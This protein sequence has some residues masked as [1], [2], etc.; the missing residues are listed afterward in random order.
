MDSNLVHV[1]VSQPPGMIRSYTKLQTVFLAPT[2]HGLSIAIR[3][4]LVVRLPLCVIPTP[5]LHCVN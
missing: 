2:I 1:K 5:V 3:E 4:F